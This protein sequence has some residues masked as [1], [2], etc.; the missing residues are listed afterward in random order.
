MID[1][2]EILPLAC[3]RADAQARAQKTVLEEASECLAGR[4]PSLDARRLL[5]GLLSRERLGS[6]G[7]GDGV[8]IPHCRFNGCTAPVACMLRTR[9][10]IEFDAPDDI[11]VDL[12]FVLAVPPG[13]QSGHLE[14]LGTLA[15]VFANAAN[16]AALRAARS[17]Q[18]LFDE[19]HRQLAL[20]QQG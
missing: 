5:E 19:L 1:F 12:L 9:H 10:A 17:D 6:T 18:A 11:G 16:L 2:R 13:D 3:V 20:A 14:I 15:R 8:A 4:H 7:L